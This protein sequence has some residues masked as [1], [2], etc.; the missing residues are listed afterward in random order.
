[1]ASTYASLPLPTLNGPGAAVDVSTIASN[2]TVVVSGSLNGASIVI[3]GSVDGGTTWAP[4]TSFQGTE[5]K[6][7]NAAV[8]EMRANVSGRTLVVPF[9]ASVAVGG[10]T[11]AAATAINLPM[12]AMNGPGAAVLASSLAAVK[13]AIVGGDFVGTSITVEASQDGGVTFA[14]VAQFANRTGSATMPGLEA[15]YLRAS[16]QGRTSVVPFTA[17]LDVGAA[18]D[19]GGGGGGGGAAQAFTYTATGIETDV[20]TVTL[21]AAMP[22]DDYVVVATMGQAA[23]FLAVAVPDGVGDRTVNDFIC[24]T[25]LALTAGDTI[26]FYV[27]ERT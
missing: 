17:T 11:I 13:T 27:T 1:M 14:P 3:E 16:V 19:G 21:P 9:S 5:T 25:S 6:Y 8:L 18:G 23:A 4:L 26:D 7:V 12:P 22:S 24:W 10:I 2:K 20:F 15:Q